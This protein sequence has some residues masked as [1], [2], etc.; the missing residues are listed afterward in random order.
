[1]THRFLR[2][3]AT[4]SRDP[5]TGSE[6]GSEPAIVES[7]VKDALD[8]C[9]AV[10]QLRFKAHCPIIDPI[11]NL[12]LVP[13]GAIMWHAYH[14]SRMIREDITSLQYW[15]LFPSPMQLFNLTEMVPTTKCEPLKDLKKTTA[16]TVCT[17]RLGLSYS[18]V[19]P[20]EKG[21]AVRAEV[22]LFDAPEDVLP[23]G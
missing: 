18:S 3:A 14:L 20:P 2:L 23:Q 1:M 12:L 10:V 13:I 15:P 4:S 7:Y 11:E 9:R 16:R 5:T 21:V 17:L 22:L 8:V 19:K 6:E